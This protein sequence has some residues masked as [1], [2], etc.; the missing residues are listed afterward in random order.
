MRQLIDTRLVGQTIKH[1]RQERHWTQ[2]QLADIAGYDQRTIRRFEASGT[3]NIETINVFAE[4]F[5]VSALD[6]L[7]GGCF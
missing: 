3:S 1:L 6:I 7:A 5:E 2:D 4:V